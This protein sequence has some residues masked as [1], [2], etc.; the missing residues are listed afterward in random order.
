[1]LK[2]STVEFRFQ[3]SST[4]V[5][6]DDSM[7]R[8]RV[9]KKMAIRVAKNSAMKKMAICVAKN[10]AIRVAKKVGGYEKKLATRVAK[11]SLNLIL[12]YPLV[13]S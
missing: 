4:M 13:N 2:V 10:S 3:T 5:Q 7:P 12:S 9:C 1:M 6:F 11:N 8:G